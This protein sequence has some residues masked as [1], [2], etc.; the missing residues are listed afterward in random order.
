MHII[1]SSFLHKEYMDI[2]NVHNECKMKVHEWMY[3]SGLNKSGTTVGGRN[4]L[5]VL[6]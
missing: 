3:M 5:M 1:Q 4:G 2:L 6:L